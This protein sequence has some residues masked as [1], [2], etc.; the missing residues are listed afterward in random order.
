MARPPKVSPAAAMKA[1]QN[2]VK[3]LLKRM[4]KAEKLI[5]KLIC[6][7]GKSLKKNKK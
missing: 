1:L 5:F 2:D 7:W 3:K 6:A 4:D